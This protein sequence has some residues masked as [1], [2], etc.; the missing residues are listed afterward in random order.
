MK[1]LLILTLLLGIQKPFKCPDHPVK[2]GYVYEEIDLSY[3]KRRMMEY[4]IVSK[5]D[6]VNYEVNVIA[7]SKLLFT[8]TLHKDYFYCMTPIQLEK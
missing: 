3:N 5:V 6:S 2:I 8:D 7:D 4:C 1:A